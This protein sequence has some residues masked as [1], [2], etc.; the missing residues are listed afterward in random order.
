MR[1]QTILLPQLE[2]HDIEELF[3]HKEGGYISFN[4]YFNLFY[5]EKH[6]RYTDIQELSLKLCA[7]GYRSI[8]LMHNSNELSRHD[9][10]ET[11]LQEY[12]F[13]FP[14]H[15][16]D[17]GVFWFILIE[18]NEDKKYITGYFEG[19][20]NKYREVNIAVAICTYRRETYILKFLVELERFMTNADQMESASHLCFYLIDNGKTLG[21]NE[22]IVSAVAKFNGIVSVI[23]N[24]NA[25]GAGGFTRGMLEALKEKR[26]KALT[27]ILL[28]DD[29]AIFMPDLFVRV[30]GFLTTLKEKYRAIT[31]GGT[32][33]REDYPYIQQASGEWF[34]NF[35]VLNEHHLVDL[36]SY[37][38]CTAPFMCSTVGNQRLYSGWWCCC[39][40][41][42]VIRDDNLP[43]P[44][45]LHHDDIEFGI[46]NRE[47]GIVFL[48]GVGVWHKGFEL[49]FTGAN[50]YY[51][52]RNSLITTALHEPQRTTWEVKRWIW[53]RITAATIEFRYA[54][55]NLVYQGL[56]DFCRGP[57]WLYSQ[58]P[59]SLNT[60][61]RAQIVLSKI[62]DLKKELT[63]DEY[64]EILKE[65]D[66]YRK[67]FG[68]ETLKRYYS[69]QHRN[70]SLLKKVTFNGWLL[71]AD[72][73]V[74]A[75]SATDSP[76]AAFRK[77]RVILFEAFTGKGVVARRDFRMLQRS[78]V[79]YIKSSG[80]IDRYYKRAA[81]EYRERLRKITSREAWENYLGLTE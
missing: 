20:S 62:E 3:I 58:D 22:N 54:E 12:E 35:A 59:D 23:P 73:K 45:F 48:N 14:Y 63:E 69:P 31:L 42:E 68:V 29:D 17:Q 32:L 28:M 75:I 53:K 7:K 47:N 56:I 74:A 70:A 5:I 1:L 30:Y 37:E 49:A 18:S 50:L 26:K 52:V 34:E 41:L 67:T 2:K 61:V 64:D 46:R 11:I 33:L 81:L 57:E 71:P 16:K 72:K 10:K 51:D 43:I 25:G 15:E 66:Q 39:Y 21:Q 78:V 55:A 19:R 65:I 9:L 13:V 36:R 6:K 60:L 27:H 79:F 24:M 44:L 76:F 8:I 40:S 38:N 4:G 80:M 77:R